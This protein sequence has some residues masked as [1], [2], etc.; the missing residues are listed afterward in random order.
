M[1]DVSLIVPPLT[2]LAQPRAYIPLG[3]AYIGAVLIKSGHNVAVTDFNNGETPPQADIYGLTVVSASMTDA[4]KIS[5][6]LR[7]ERKHVVVGGVYATLSS[8]PTLAMSKA[9]QVVIGEGELAFLDIVEG[10]EREPF[11][12][13][14]LVRELDA[15]PFPARHLFNNVV[16]YSGIHGQEK[17]VGATTLIG[18]RGCPYNCAFCRR[19]L[20]LHHVRHRDAT[21]IVEEMTQVMAFFDVKH[22]RFVDDV[23][24]LDRARTLK[25][26]EEM[27]RRELE[28]SWICITRADHLDEQL[29]N[30]MRV[31][32]CAEIHVGVESGSPR[33][34][35][36]MNKSEH[37]ETLERAIGKIKE[38]G[39]RAKA[40]IM[41]GYPSE[42][43]EDRDLTLAFLRRVKPSKVTVSHYAAEG[44]WYY[45]DRD[46]AF[47][48][49]KR[50]AEE[51]CESA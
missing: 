49:F 15:L 42:T 28:A 26:C 12:H 6:Q 31:A 19:P 3:L 50:R 22:F 2:G 7:R 11:V 20:Y 30:S 13:G 23:F 4:F 51:L 21:N 48:I 8:Q 5:R 35:K 36:A 34:L 25:L 17:G 44:E 46:E 18:S 39:I 29:L 41:Y 9:N 27:N 47:Q 33:I 14:Q 24:T 45:P 40:Y 38:A 16:D 32:G 10:R 43:E 37:V 1:T